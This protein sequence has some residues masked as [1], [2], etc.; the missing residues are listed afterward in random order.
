M[1]YCKR[2]LYPNTKPDLYFEDG[3]C[4]AC[5]VFD[6]RE[7]IDWNLRA[8]SLKQIIK[9]N[10]CK[11]NNYDCIVPVSGGKD[12]HYQ[13]LKALEYGLKPL[14]VNATTDDLSPLGHRNLTNI[15]KLG[16][17]CIE[18]STNPKIR[19]KINK[20]SLQTIGDISWA[21]HV[22]IFTIPI[23]EAINRNIPLI[24]WGE[25]PQNEYGGPP[26]WQ[27]KSDQPEKWLAEFGGLN[28]LRVNDI[29]DQGIATKEQMYQ[30]TYPYKVN[31]TRPPTSI[32][33]GYYLPWDGYE[34]SIIAQKHGFELNP[35]PV[36]G[37]GVDY[38]NLDNHQ[39][40]IHDYFKYLKFGFG[41]ATDIA[42]NHI[43]RKNITRKEGIEFVQQYD[44]NFPTTYLG[45]SLEDIL[46]NI[47]LTVYEFMNIA[48]KFTNKKLF[49]NRVNQ[50]RPVPKF[51]VE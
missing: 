29:I 23:R 25:N 12:S 3:V 34:N 40:G 9:E 17:D 18:V 2:C 47:G 8:E 21:E 27:L 7:K 32:Y 13:T 48:D 51:R 35:E 44:G 36:S 4:S 28:G 6:E 22:T 11:T 50:V 14:A 5:I 46:V 30:Y 38:E 49:H 45:K 1:I 24:I 15:S 19:R 42:C 10:T 43:R 37:C 41:R 16:V 33:L 31:S 39:T 26:T 20:Y